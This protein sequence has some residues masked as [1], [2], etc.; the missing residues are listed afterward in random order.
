MQSLS[1]AYKLDESFYGTGTS[2]T[3]VDG[4]DSVEGTSW[5]SGLTAD[6]G[7]HTLYVALFDQEVMYW[8]PTV[9]DLLTKVEVLGRRADRMISTSLLQVQVMYM[10][11]MI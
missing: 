11:G 10:Q 4:N 1:W 6:G 7:S 2:A 9:T 5:L 8:P 3:Q